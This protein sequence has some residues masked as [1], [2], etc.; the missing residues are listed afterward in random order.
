[1]EETH[2]GEGTLPMICQLL[3]GTAKVPTDHR[4][5]QQ[6][7]DHTLPLFKDVG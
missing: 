6:Q 3:P 4:P 1:M 7:Q 5:M 2:G